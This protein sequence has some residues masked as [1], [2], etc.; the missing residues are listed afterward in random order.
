MKRQ[1]FDVIKDW[2]IVLNF[3]NDQDWTD[4]AE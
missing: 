1:F 3:R 2:Q 4:D